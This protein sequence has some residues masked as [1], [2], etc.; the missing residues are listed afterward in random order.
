MKRIPA[1]L[2]AVLLP[3]AAFAQDDDGGFL[4]RLLEDNLSG[5]GR[6]VQI[7]GFAGA[8]SSQATIEQLTIADGQGVWLTLEDVV[9][10]WSRLALLRGRV[11]VNSLTAGSIMLPRLPVA[12]EDAVELPDP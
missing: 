1:Y 8:L 7:R 10:D 12:S 4:E 11:E 3:T 9:L 2:L 5:A 6:D